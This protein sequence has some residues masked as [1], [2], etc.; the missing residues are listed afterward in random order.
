MSF[1][2]FNR[3]S[4]PQKFFVSL[5]LTFLLIVS[6]GFTSIGATTGITININ[7]APLITDV[8][9]VIIQGRTMVPMRAI[10]EALEAHV[11]WDGDTE[12]ITGTKDNTVVVLHL[13]EGLALINEE[14]QYLD[15]PPTLINGR[16]MVPTRFIAESLGADV[17]W[18][19]ATST[20]N[21]LY[22]KVLSPHIPKSAITTQEI[23]SLVQPATV[24]IETNRGK[25]SGFIVTS[26]EGKFLVFTNAHVARGS[27]WIT[28]T[29]TEGK[30]YPADI[31]KINNPGD[32]A[33]LSITVLENL[34]YAS[35][36][37]FVSYE[38]V[39][40]GEDI[41]VFGN[42][43]GYS[44]TV[45]KGIVSGKRKLPLASEWG[46]PVDVIQHDAATAPGSS[47]GLVINMQGKIIGI[48]TAGSVYGQGF[49]FAI[50]AYYCLWLMGQEEYSIKDDYYSWNVERA[51]D[52]RLFM[53][54]EEII[55]SNISKATTLYERTN[56]IQNELLP[57]LYQWYEHISYYHPKYNAIKNLKQLYLDYIITKID[58]SEAYVSYPSMK[59]YSLHTELINNY[60]NAWARYSNEWEK[61]KKQLGV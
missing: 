53:D 54:P 24:L 11:E 13:G 31:L 38:N 6:F 33:I 12:K 2:N 45:T 1:L 37:N 52:Y 47:G 32:V 28:I 25:G 49:N 27:S 42:P 19:N 36:N 23:V 8:A 20:V 3:P 58:Y 46:A 34:P 41:L 35:I 18:D 17:S 43:F 44:Q 59:H 26:Y 60:N 5:M 10:F 40:I 51:L 21:I 39:E 55:S 4:E 14:L 50:P 61:L 9:P 16:T 15:V 57:L 7:G 56:L 48:H 29:T 30:K 22:D